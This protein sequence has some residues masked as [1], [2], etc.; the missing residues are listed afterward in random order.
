[1]FGL[2][3]LLGRRIA[4]RLACRE[5][6]LE[7]KSGES[8]APMTTRAQSREPTN[9]RVSGRKPYLPGARLLLADAA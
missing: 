6:P 5:P 3:D 7:P 8:C 4:I 9:A 1:M 2:N